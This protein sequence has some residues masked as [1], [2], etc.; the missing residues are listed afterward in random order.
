MGYVCANKKKASLGVRCLYSLNKA[1]LCKWNWHFASK[2]EAFWRQIISGKYGEM[3]GGWCSK[4]V[5]GGYGIGLWKVIRKLWDLVF[6]RV[7]F[8]VRNGKR[9]K[10][11]KDKCCGDEPL[12]ISFPS[13]FALSNS[14]DAWV[15]DLWQHSNERGV[16]NPIFP[17][18]LNDWEIDMME[19][20]LARLQDK[21]VDEGSEDKIWWVEAKN[22]TFSVK[23][24]YA[25]LETGS[26]VQFPASVVWN[27][28]VPPKVSFFA[29]EAT[30]GK[31]LTLDQ[32]QKRGW[33]LV[34]RCCLCLAHEESIDHILLHCGKP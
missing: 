33:S 24:L 20:F 32:L 2:R 7:S 14:K 25:S 4:E 29:W 12:N 9:I 22:G 11:W 28:W 8:S 27:A 5:R 21:V 16:W 15:V 31:V 30:W 17:R 3:E 10:F 34:N 26:L 18:P 13:L 6:C 19:R 23:S 1:L